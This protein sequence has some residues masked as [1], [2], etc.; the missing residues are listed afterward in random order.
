MNEQGS[1]GWVKDRCGNVTG[2]RITDV[3]AKPMKGSKESTTRRNYKAELVSELLTGRVQEGFVSWDMKRGTELEPFAR[4]DYEVERGVTI[5]N[6]GFVKHPTLA[7]CGASPD[8]LIEKDGL[9]EFKAPKTANHLDYLTAGIVPMEYRPQMLW[10]MACTG[11][12]WCDFVSYD[13]NMPERLQLFIKR[14]ERDD[15][16]IAEIEQEVIKF[17]AEIDEIIANLPK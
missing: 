15:V 6:V 10:E 9:V 1:D 14:F 2:S 11:R 5:T 3:L 4:A 12:Q 17:N 8:G 7:R 16:R 13:P